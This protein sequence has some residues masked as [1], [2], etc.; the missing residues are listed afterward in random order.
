MWPAYVINLADNTARLAAVSRV[1][2]AQGVAFERIEAVNGWALSEAE[3]GAAYDASRNATEGRQP[4]VPAEIG[5]YLSHIAAW[6]RIAEGEAAGGFIFEDDFDATA[7]LAMV[8]AALSADRASDR[9][10][11]WDMVKLFSLDPAAGLGM[12]RELAPGVQIG[13]PYR[14]PTCLIGYG[15][16]KA[17]AAHLAARARPFFRPVDEDQKFIWETGLRVALVRPAPVVLGDQQAVTGTVGKARR[18]GK[19]SGVG[20]MLHQLLY[21]LRYRRALARHRRKEGWHE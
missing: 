8:L 12:A 5:C 18:A 14:V 11:D 20:Q 2:G 13:I 17:A 3:I 16:T 6:E 10:G 21:G 19:R 4:L 7:S 9:A 1:L 15:L